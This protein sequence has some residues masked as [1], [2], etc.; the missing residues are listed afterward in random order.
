MSAP[1]LSTTDVKDLTII[2]TDA[3]DTGTSLYFAIRS[4]HS[5]NNALTIDNVTV[6]SNHGGIYLSGVDN[7]GV[8]S[9]VP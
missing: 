5:S 8:P 4:D 6:V 3:T 2:N 7:D 9:S 1:A